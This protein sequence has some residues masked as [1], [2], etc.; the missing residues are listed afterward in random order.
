MQLTVI[1]AFSWAHRG[2][3]V[4]YF[5]PGALIETDDDDLITV[6]LAEKWTAAE[7]KAAP[8]APEN[9]ADKPKKTKSEAADSGVPATE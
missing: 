5:E 9:K 1:A 7:S 3:Q 6:S 4:E 2:V 8:R